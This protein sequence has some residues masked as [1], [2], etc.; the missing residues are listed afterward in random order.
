MEKT[1][2]R[3]VGFVAHYF[4]LLKN[5]QRLSVNLDFVYGGEWS[6]MET[7]ALSLWQGEHP[8]HAHEPPGKKR[9]PRPSVWGFEGTD[10]RPA[11]S[12]YAGQHD[13]KGSSGRDWRA[14]KTG[15]SPSESL[16]EAGLH[17]SHACCKGSPG[18]E[19]LALFRINARRTKTIAR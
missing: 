2:L 12:A 1:A 3:L 19:V 6:Q 15:H 13:Y 16:V 14:K 11:R 18:G 8:S 10:L 9:H 17:K 5:Q 7:L 4:G